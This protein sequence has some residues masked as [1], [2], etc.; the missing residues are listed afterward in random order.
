MGTL[1]LIARIRHVL[2]WLPVI[3]NDYDWDHVY[4]WTILQFKL[5]MMKRHFEHH[6]VS[7][8]SEQNVLEINAC[9]EALDR[10]IKDE[11]LIDEQMEIVDRNP[12]EFREDPNRPGL[13]ILKRMPEADS[14]RLA[15]L[16]NK[17]ESMIVSDS[18]FVTD[19]MHNH[20]RS[21][22]D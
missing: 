5:K 7:L 14:K 8:D 9:I 17:A 11:Y 12:L 20:W 6:G 15:E 2:A 13:M 3:W 1:G 19:M 18:R 10:M 16:A 4:L 21:W 22:W